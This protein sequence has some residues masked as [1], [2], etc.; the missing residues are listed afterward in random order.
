MSQPEKE[1]TK[2]LE[3]PGYRVYKHEINE[4]GK[5]LKLWVRRNAGNQKLVCGG[6]G[7]GVQ[8]IREIYEREV[9]DLPWGEYAVSVIIDC[10]EWIVHVVG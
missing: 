8:E 9:R 3:W 1:W 2:I 5:T 7:Q 10:T 6:C 4:K